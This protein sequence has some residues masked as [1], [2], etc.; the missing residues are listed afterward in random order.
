MAI[1]NQCGEAGT[2]NSCDFEINFVAKDQPE[3]TVYIM[4][5]DLTTGAYV[6]GDV[7][8]DIDSTFTIDSSSFPNAQSGH[9]YQISLPLSANIEDKG[10]I[11]VYGDTVTDYT[12][13]QFNFVD[14]IA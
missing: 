12:C 3:T 4:I 14:I 10:I 8:T 6:S 7:L 1:C 5:L 13:L 2:Y 9:L 11:Q